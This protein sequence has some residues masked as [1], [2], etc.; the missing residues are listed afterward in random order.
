MTLNKRIKFFLTH[1]I[2]SLCLVV[3]IV[4]WGFF[5]WYPQPLPKAIGLTYIFS[6][7][8]VVDVIIGPVLGFIVYKQDKKS[9]KMDLGIIILIQLVALSYGVFSIFQGRPVWLVYYVD[10]FELIR[11]NEIVEENIEKA[12]P[13]Y[14]HPSWLKPQYVAVEFAKDTKQRQND[15]FAEVLGG[16]SLAQR[17]ERYV[18]LLQAKTQLQLSALPLQALEQFNDKKQM[19]KILSKYPTANVWL[20]LKANKVDMVVL[21]NKETA[22][23]VKV[24]DLRPWS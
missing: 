24:V 3:F 17:P 4:L 1:L 14:R 9:L 8:L 2:L 6:M 21:I 12:L 19:Q 23:V 13:Q 10:R 16:V 7:L 22:Q 20:P 11:N 5:N 15:M 18:P